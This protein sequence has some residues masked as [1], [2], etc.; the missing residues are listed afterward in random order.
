MNTGMECLSDAL[1]QKV[2]KGYFSGTHR[3]VEPARTIERLRPMLKAMGITRIA[4][5]TGLDR[6]GIPVVMV[7]RPNSRSVSVS[8]GKGLTLDAAK[9]SGLMESIESWHA[10]RTN[11]ALEFS[12]FRDMSQGRALI[13]VD[14][15]PKCC[16]SR[17]SSDRQILWMQGY[18]LFTGED[19]WLPHESVH[20]D[21][22]VPQAAG[23]GCF[24]ANTNG[25]ASG[26]HLLEAI[27]H[28]L[29]E[30]IERDA[31]TLWRQKTATAQAA[32]ALDISSV[33]NE[34]C[35]DLLR[36]LDRKGF[37]VCVWD[38]GTDI[39]LPCFICLIIERCGDYADPEFGSGCHCDSA[40]AFLRALTE[41]VQVRTTF[42]SGSRD[43]YNRRD[44]TFENRQNRQN[45]CL[46]LAEQKG[47]RK[48]PSINSSV[49]LTVNEDLDLIL[50]RLSSIGIEQAVA[51]DLSVPAFGI[52]V[53]KMVIPG[54]EG[55]YEGPDSDYVPGPRAIQAASITQ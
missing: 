43:D 49:H 22:T 5:I 29:C 23:S 50:Q 4:N 6:I 2:E 40:V 34:N 52:P 36:L 27:S 20:S 17:Y 24:P 18:D 45:A 51:I 28:G 46:A 30:V 15:L 32:C 7:C 33:D 54:L 16:G 31:I 19:I 11:Q 1:Q 37:E 14:R 44:F 42:I 25:L 8:Q 9:A 10:E 39:G 35:R 53:V 26:N 12:S 38:A 47:K 13:D 3:C 41:A 48:F 21:F 55:A